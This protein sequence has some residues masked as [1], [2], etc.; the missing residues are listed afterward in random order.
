MKLPLLTLG[1]V[2]VMIGMCAGQSV[3]YVQGASGLDGAAL[4]KASSHGSVLMVTSASPCESP[5]IKSL[6]A[7]HWTPTGPIRSDTVSLWLNSYFTLVKPH[8]AR[9]SVWFERCSPSSVQI[10]E[11]TDDFTPPALRLPIPKELQK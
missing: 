10:I 1:L 7:S 9:Y 11:V 3:H 2:T 4:R 8:R 5:A 6:P